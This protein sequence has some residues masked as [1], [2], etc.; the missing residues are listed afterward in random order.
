MT[1][2]NDIT[3]EMISTKCNNIQYRD[4]YDKIFSKQ[5]KK[6]DEPHYRIGDTVYFHLGMFTDDLMDG[7]VCHIF[8]DV[9]E[10]LYVIRLETEIE[11]LYEVRTYSQLSN[12]KNGTY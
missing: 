1:T 7:K 9:E 11:P 4:N 10:I 2:Q 5:S 12:T 8:K 6:K 3:G